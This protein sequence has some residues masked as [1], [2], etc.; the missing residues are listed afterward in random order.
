MSDVRDEFAAVLDYSSCFIY[1]SRPR[2]RNQRAWIYQRMIFIC[3]RDEECLLRGRINATR[4]IR[5]GS[6]FERIL[7]PSEFICTNTDFLPIKEILVTLH[8]MYHTMSHLYG[9]CSH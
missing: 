4:S 5:L 9:N 3:Y 7:I 1:K 8:C 6:F 2:I